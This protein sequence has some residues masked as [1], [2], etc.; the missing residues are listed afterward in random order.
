MR[1]EED[2][3]PGGKTRAIEIMESGRLKVD[4]VMDRTKRKSE[5]QN[6]IPQIMEKPDKKI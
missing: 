4:D 1:R 6:Y 5:I 2:R 3:K